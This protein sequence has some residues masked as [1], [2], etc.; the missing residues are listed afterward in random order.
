MVQEVHPQ[1]EDESTNGIKLSNG[2]SPARVLALSTPN[3][4]LRQ[5]CCSSI[6]RPR[7]TPLTFPHHSDSF[8]RS[9]VF[10]FCTERNRREL[11]LQLEPELRECCCVLMKS[12]RGARE[13]YAQF[14]CVNRNSHSLRFGTRYQPQTIRILQFSFGLVWE[15]IT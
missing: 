14:Q 6:C 7:S 2:M 13:K 10:F 3:R 4:Y 5:P 9:F 12:R 11:Q 8:V 15:N 1:S